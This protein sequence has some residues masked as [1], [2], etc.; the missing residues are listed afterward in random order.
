MKSVNGKCFWELLN[1]SVDS[2][3]NKISSIF[4]CINNTVNADVYTCSNTYNENTVWWKFGIGETAFVDKVPIKTVDIW[5]KLKFYIHS[6]LQNVIKY[7]LKN[8]GSSFFIYNPMG[9]QTISFC[10]MKCL[11]I[12]EHNDR[13]LILSDRIV[14]RNIRHVWEIL[15]QNSML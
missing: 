8:T 15:F 7:I 3:F 12:S 5:K 13:N 6:H 1:G 2:K 9:F 4:L 10:V 11:V 14:D